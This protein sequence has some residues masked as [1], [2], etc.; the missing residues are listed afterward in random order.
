MRPTAVTAGESGHGD[1]RSDGV[2]GYSFGRVGWR[3][4]ADRASV[5]TISACEL[6]AGPCFRRERVVQ[7]RPRMPDDVATDRPS[8]ARIYDYFLGGAHNF[9]IDRRARRADRSSCG[10]HLADTMRAEPGVPAPRGRRYL[11]GRASTSSS[12]SARA[13][14]PSATSTRSPRAINPQ[15]RIVYV[16]IDPV[17]VAHSRSILDGNE[18]STAVVAG[19]PAR[20]GVGAVRGA[21]AGLLDLSRTDRRAAGRRAALRAGRRRSGRDRRDPARSRSRPA[22]TW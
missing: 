21:R 10:P 8:A 7:P 1:A 13:S 19:R 5:N 20:P 22:A 3:A 4:A 6:A 2:D 15:A 9:E 18:A 11:V 17:A 14:R 12:T 16:D